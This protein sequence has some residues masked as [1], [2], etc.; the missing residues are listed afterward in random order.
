MK[1]KNKLKP[2]ETGQKPAKIK[3]ILGILCPKC[4]ARMWR[5]I[6]VRPYKEARTIRRKRCAVCD[7]RILTQEK[8]V[9]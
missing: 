1:A 9:G 4:G 7:H 2:D 5:T 6:Y 8:L 3:P